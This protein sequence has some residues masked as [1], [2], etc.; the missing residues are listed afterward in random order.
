MSNS[1]NAQFEAQML[2]YVEKS[3]RA[4]QE[5]TKMVLV[6][7]GVRL[8]ERSPVGDPPSWKKQPPWLPKNYLPGTFKNNWHLGV[9][10]PEHDIFL[11]A[12]PSGAASVTR[13][14]L[15]IPRFP[16]GHIY[17]F[18]NN[19]PYATA[20]ENGHSKRCPPNGMVALTIIEYESIVQDVQRR[21]ANGERPTTKR[22]P[23]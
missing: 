6:D 22:I 20:L 7:I 4:L 17:Y 15:A 2:E 14:G 21:Y 23:S 19:I 18:S 10:S 3:K 9:D 12:D 13:I 8:V 1:L 11:V 5:M 16:A